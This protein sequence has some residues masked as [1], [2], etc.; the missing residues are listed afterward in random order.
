MYDDEKILDTNL[1]R[2]LRISIIN[3]KESKFDISKKI[4]DKSDYQYKERLKFTLLTSIK[5]LYKP[6][7][8]LLEEEK[9]TKGLIDTR[10]F[11]DI[12]NNKPCLI[13]LY[14]HIEENN[15]NLELE[16][17]KIYNLLEEIKKYDENVSIFLFIIFKDNPENPYPFESEDKTKKYNL[18]NIIDKELIFVFPDEQIW[19]YI[20]FQSFCS[21]IVFYARKYYMKLKVEIKEKK[22]K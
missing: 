8:N 9:N 18:R 7:K 20:E 21:N 16:Q 22:N 10:W 17:Q 19:K 14:Y 4:L 3:P 13:I 11:E 15:T 12:T 2:I 1:P 6:K 5:N